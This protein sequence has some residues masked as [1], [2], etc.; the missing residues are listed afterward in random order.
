MSASNFLNNS[1]LEATTELA[2]ELMDEIQGLINSL[3]VINYEIPGGGGTLSGSPN[4]IS[5]NL[6][7]KYADSGTIVPGVSAY[8]ITPAYTVPAV[9]APAV[10]GWGTVNL[11]SP[12]SKCTSE[13]PGTPAITTTPAFTVPAVISPAI[14]ALTG[15]YSTELVISANVSGISDSLNPLFSSVTFSNGTMT[16]PNSTGL[17]TQSIT[18]NLD[19][20][21]D[22]N[23]VSITG[24]AAFNDLSVDI[25]GITTN[26]GDVSTGQMNLV[27]I[28]NIPIYFNAI[29]NIPSYNVTPDRSVNGL[30]YELFPQTNGLFAEDLSISTGVTAIADFINDD[31]LSYLTEFWNYSVVPLYTAVGAAAPVA[32]SQ[33]LANTIE[34]EADSVQVEINTAAESELNSLLASQLNTI[35]PYVQAITA[36]VWNYADYPIVPNGNYTD[37]ILSS[38]LFSGLDLSNS[39]FVNSNAAGA[40]FSYTNLTNTD[41]TGAN[42]SGTNFTGAVNSGQPFKGSVLFSANLTDSSLN[43]EGAFY[44]KSTLFSYNSDA[45]KS[46]MLLFSPYQFIAGNKSLRKEI[47]SDINKAIGL[48][49]ADMSSCG[50]PNKPGLRS[51][52][53]TGQLKLDGFNEGRYLRSLRIGL[54]DK[55]TDYINSEPSHDR[56]ETIA[57]YFLATK[58]TW[59]E[60]DLNKYIFSNPELIGEF[61]NNSKKAIK[62]AKQHYLK[63]GFFNNFELNDSDLYNDYVARFPEALFDTGGVFDES[64]LASHFL[65]IGINQGQTLA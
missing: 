54:R 37:A 31:L 8:T 59:S 44:D 64:S 41:F 1:A 50:C 7:Q 28:P 48:F 34:R 17:A 18:Y 12:W 23:A 63:T 43:L 47:G 3:W 38:G 27:D 51:D 20:I 26:F 21:I 6:S 62:N 56:G 33:T 13:V 60:S 24:R 58:D 39:L 29:I 22:G 65:T 25:A 55:I 57:R 2:V 45:D 42:L 53:I 16:Q 5:Y 4:N 52:V 36:V 32:P 9:V 49:V 10:P 14:P 40:D 19:Q 11:C 15:G 35:Q 30:A 61:G 46:R